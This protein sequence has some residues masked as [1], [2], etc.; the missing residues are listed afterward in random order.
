MLT[1]EQLAEKFDPEN[2]NKAGA[3]FDIQ[4]LDWLNGRWLREGLTETDFVTR[5]L[6]W[7]QENDRF[8]EGMKLSQSRITRLSDLPDLAGFL[9]K[10][11]LG[12]SATTS[13]ISRRCRSPT[14]RRSSKRRRRPISRRSSNGMSKAS[15]RN[16]APSPSGW[17]RS[18]AMC[19]RRSSSPFPARRAS[20]PLFDSM[21]ILGRSVVRQRL[22][23]AAT[24]VKLGVEAEKK[25]NG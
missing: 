25:N 2:L 23:S 17:K 7:A 15:R 16:C 1:M 5:V 14:F 11:D 19:S 9:L 20:L 3:I 10:G 13:P 8:R 24:A 12:L 22:K 6:A 21:A 4:K 18:C